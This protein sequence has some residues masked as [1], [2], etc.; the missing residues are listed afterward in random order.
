MK[1][2]N[3]KKKTKINSL[4][5]ELFRSYCDQFNQ[6]DYMEG[7]AFNNLNSNSIRLS[8][9]SSSSSSKSPR[10]YP[11]KSSSINSRYF[12]YKSK[13]LPL[14]KNKELIDLLVSNNKFTNDN[15]SPYLL[16]VEDFKNKRIYNFS[17]GFLNINS[18]LIYCYKSLN[19]EKDKMVLLFLSVREKETENDNQESQNNIFADI[20]DMVVNIGF[21]KLNYISK[22]NNPLKLAYYDESEIESMDE[23]FKVDVTFKKKIE[24]KWNRYKV[25]TEDNEFELKWYFPDNFTDTKNSIFIKDE[26]KEYVENTNVDINELFVSENKKNKNY[27]K[28]ICVNP[29]NL[30]YYNTKDWIVPETSIYEVCGTYTYKEIELYNRKFYCFENNAHSRFIIVLDPDVEIFYLCNI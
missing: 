20:K 15:I 7:G 3:E 22:E 19:F 9:S 16:M 30:H 25:S 28:T 14:F 2:F 26:N 24:E 8:S 17:L 12:D 27:P 4:L 23:Y 10:T 5:M 21:Y 29:Y 6:D 13:N 11:E 18:Q 1:K